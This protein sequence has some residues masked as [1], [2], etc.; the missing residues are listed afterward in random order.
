MNNLLGILLRFRE[1]QVAL[2][3][4]ISK[5]F[6]SIQIPELDQMTHRF[7]WRDLESHRYPDT[8][9]MTA[10]NM[11]DKPSGSIAISALK[12]TAEMK[13]KDYPGSSKVIIDNSYMDD[14]VDSVA[15]H[16]VAINTTKEVDKILA[17]G[18][19]SCQKVV[20]FWTIITSVFRGCAQYL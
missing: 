4:D 3:G 17:L 16:D 11:G 7:L 13:R 12:K 15:S 5:M 20:Y 19:F 14:I 9:V 10:L 1:E 8:Y 2:V 6:H 18:G